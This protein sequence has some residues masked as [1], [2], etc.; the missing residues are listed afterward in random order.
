M[1]T[2]ALA[3]I[4]ATPPTIYP[5]GPT[6]LVAL[7]TVTVDEVS[8]TSAQDL[9]PTAPHAPAPLPPVPDSLV[10]DSVPAPAK[11]SKRVTVTGT[12]AKSG[13]RNRWV[14][15]ASDLEIMK[16]SEKDMELASLKAAKPRSKSKHISKTAAAKDSAEAA[17]P[18][19]ALVGD[20]DTV[21]DGEG[22]EEDGRVSRGN[23]GPLS[24]A[25]KVKIITYI[26]DE[27]CWPRFKLNKH[28]VYIKIA[29][30]VLSD[31]E[32]DGTVLV[33]VIQNYW[34][35]NAWAKYK[36]SAVAISTGNK[37][38]KM[39]AGFLAQVLKEFQNSE[40]FKIIDAIA[41][42]NVDVMHK[43]DVN[44]CSNISDD[45]IEDVTPWKR[46]KHSPSDESIGGHHHLLSEA[47]DAIKQKAH[48]TRLLPNKTLNLHSVVI[49]VRR[50]SARNTER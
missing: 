8:L 14:G 5:P 4:P 41:Y 10:P 25:Q 11:R 1:D 23:R 15:G 36:A 48:H 18:E 6:P 34:I 17:K 21:G 3:H 43:E 46:P 13:Q 40:I 19:M 28:L 9:L 29:N 27:E 16:L 12:S 50:R 38:K 20:D 35:N 42:T 24:Y 32:T 22:L 49:N 37:C 33:E 39:E 7:T 31:D 26:A 2:P 30:K 47:M 45:E 44:S